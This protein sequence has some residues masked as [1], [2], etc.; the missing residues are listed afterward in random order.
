MHIGDFAAA[1]QDAE[2]D[3]QSAPAPADT[4]GWFGHAI[5]LRGSVEAMTVMQFAAIAVKGINIG[6]MDALAAI[7]RFLED[8]VHPDD[9]Q[10]FQDLSRANTAT[11]DQYLVLI[12]GAIEA[13][14]AR[15]TLRPSDSVGG[16]SSTG[17]S[18]RDDS[19]S[20]VLGDH[21][22]LVPVASLVTTGL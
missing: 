2:K 9:W 7:Y 5:K 14:A 4:F 18:S 12:K 13:A 17:E 11:M 20:P 21:E 16:P 3:N 22:Q 6:E 10:Q 1:V 8:V 19:S 15:P